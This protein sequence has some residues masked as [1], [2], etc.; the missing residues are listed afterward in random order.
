VQLSP[1]GLLVAG[2]CFHASGDQLRRFRESVAD[3]LRG[4]RLVRIVARLGEQD[5]ELKGERLKTVPRGFPGDHPRV[6][7]LKYK[8]LYA[9]ASYEPDDALHSAEAADRV[10]A[11]WRQVRPLNEWAADHIG[12]TA[13][14]NPR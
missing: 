1:E 3:D 9:S 5:W 2:G 6:D 4:E 13:G 12:V 14:A 8:S 11:R 10:R 7:L